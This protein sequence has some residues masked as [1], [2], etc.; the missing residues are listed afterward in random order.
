MSEPRGFVFKARIA[1]QRFAAYLDSP[2]K[3]VR[4]W[5]DWGRIGGTWGVVWLGQPG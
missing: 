3:P 2:V 5:D 4:E 1:P